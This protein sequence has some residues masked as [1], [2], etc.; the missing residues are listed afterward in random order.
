MTHLC[1]NTKVKQHSNEEKITH[2]KPP[3]LVAGSNNIRRSRKVFAT[4]SRTTIEKQGAASSF[5]EQLIPPEARSCD[6][7]KCNEIIQKFF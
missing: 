6:T 1:H 3:R 5:G 2:F 4:P 7:T